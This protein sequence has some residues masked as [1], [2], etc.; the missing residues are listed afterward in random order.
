MK[1]HTPKNVSILHHAPI[2]NDKIVKL[3]QFSPKKVFYKHL[4]SK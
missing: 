3:N 2:T 1:I 4:G